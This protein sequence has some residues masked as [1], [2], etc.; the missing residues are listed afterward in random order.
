MQSS[1]SYFSYMQVKQP[2][3][4]ITRPRMPLLMTHVCVGSTLDHNL[5]S[6]LFANPKYSFI[7]GDFIN[8]THRFVGVIA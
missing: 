8:G 1:P 6:F 7:A 3:H 2:V 5:Y 4:P